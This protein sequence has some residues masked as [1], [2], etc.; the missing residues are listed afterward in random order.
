MTSNAVNGGTEAE[1]G[2]SLTGW[3]TWVFKHEWKGEPDGPGEKPKANKERD[4]CKCIGGMGRRTLQGS[5]RQEH[6]VEERGKKLKLEIL[7]AAAVVA[8]GF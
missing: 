2:S 6:E 3:E 4:L 5:Q 1:R 7:V 8:T